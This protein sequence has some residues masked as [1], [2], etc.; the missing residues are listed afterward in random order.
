MSTKSLRVTTLVSA[1]ILF[2][3]LSIASFKLSAELAVEAALLFLW[4]TLI[5]GLAAVNIHRKSARTKKVLNAALLA[6][7]IVA[8]ATL[9]IGAS[10]A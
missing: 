7:P 1:C 4:L 2:L 5:S 8:V 10:H 3:A 9:A 6:L